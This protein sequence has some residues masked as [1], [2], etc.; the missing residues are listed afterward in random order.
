MKSNREFK[1]EARAAL[2]GNWTQS[3]L[4]ELVQTVIPGDFI[5]GTFLRNPVD[6]GARNAYRKLLH[7]DGQVLSNAFN[8]AFDSK[9]VHRLLTMLL[10]EV[11]TILW[12][13]LMIV[14]G[15]IKS[16]SYALVPYLIED[17]PELCADDCIK[18]SRALMKGHK[19]DLFLL[20]LSFIGWFILCMIT[21]GI[22]FLWLMPYVKTSYAAFYEDLTG[23]TEPSAADVDEQE[24]TPE[25]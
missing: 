1:A 3:V 21:C 23:Y 2:K 12:A 13:L 7:G 14:P 16:Y 5:V 20:D 17:N 25:A 18:R 8:N 15:I 24:A 22:G 11:Y 10:K 4:T 9:Y 6:A 19:K